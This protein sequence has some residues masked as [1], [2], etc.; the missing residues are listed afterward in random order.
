MPKKSPVAKSQ[1]PSSLGS[2]L[3]ILSQVAT[4]AKG[5]TENLSSRLEHHVAHLLRSMMG[6]V[7]L[8]VLM[9]VGCIYFFTGLLMYIAERSGASLG[10]V[11]GV[12]GAFLFLTCALILAL[13]GK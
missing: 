6:L 11:F 3:E 2:V 10:L 1:A 13:K 9:A 12:G 8:F 5:F 4:W 7:L